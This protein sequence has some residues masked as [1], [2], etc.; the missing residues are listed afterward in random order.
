MQ[1]I[2]KKD[3]KHIL[4]ISL[5][6]VSLVSMVALP[7]IHPAWAEWEV[8]GEGNLYGTEDVALFS[9]TRRLAKDQDPTQPVIDSELAEQGS[10]AVLEPVLQIDTFFPLFERDTELKVRG[11][12]FIYLDNSRFNH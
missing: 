9:A 10:D 4:V 6:I 5:I 3:K 8:R 12:G 2:P 11:Q 1:P 7:G